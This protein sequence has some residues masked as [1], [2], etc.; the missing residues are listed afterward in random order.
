MDFAN[1]KKYLSI[2]KI[3]IFIKSLTGAGYI[4]VAELLRI[5]CLLY[6]TESSIL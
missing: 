2:L 4:N 6:L 3:M 1:Y 5:I